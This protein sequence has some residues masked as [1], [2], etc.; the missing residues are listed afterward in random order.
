MTTPEI[1]H[2]SDHELLPEQLLLLDPKTIFIPDRLRKEIN[3]GQLNELTGSISKTGQIHP[4]RVRPIE[5]DEGGISTGQWALVAGFR[6]LTACTALEIKV[7]AVNFAR[8]SPFLRTRAELEENL[9]RQDM[10]WQEKADATKKLHELFK[11]EFEVGDIKWTQEQTAAILGETQA[12]LNIKLKVADAIEKN[13]ELRKANSRKAALRAIDM[14]ASHRARLARSSQAVSHATT[15]QSKLFLGDA[16]D[17]IRQLEAGSIDLIFTDPPYGIDYYDK[18]DGQGQITK[19][20]QGGI[21]K[22]DDSSE[23]TRDLLIDLVPHWFRVTHSASWIAVMMNEANYGFLRELMEDCCAVHFAYRDGDGGVH[24]FCTD[25]DEAGNCKFLKVEEPHW[26]WYRPNSH[27]PSMYPERHAQNAYERILVLNRGV[28]RL[29][30]PCQNVL[31]I[32]NEYG[33]ER[34]HSMQK[35]LALCREII[36]RLSLPG[37]RVLDSTFGSGNILKAASMS[38][39]DFRGSEQNEQLFNMAIQ[40]ISEVFAGEVERLAPV[41]ADD[42]ENDEA[43][44]SELGVEET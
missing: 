6:R 22:Y 16:R 31:N 4:I 12:N 18:P 41:G 9:Y 28:A 30:F 10:T 39:R 13:P 7:K 11:A 34:W 15:V 40:S 27:L 19:S 29:S 21:S 32:D 42:E 20:N 25:H 44:L 8:M 33:N 5:D 24:D 38:S 17:Y 14:E 2:D 23:T 35:P 1:A 37:E 43:L 3:A 36:N 26:I